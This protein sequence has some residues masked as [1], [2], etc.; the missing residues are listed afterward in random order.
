MPKIERSIEVETKPE[1]VFDMICKVEEFVHL[2]KHIKEIKK[3]GADTF[4]WSVE[5]LGKTFSWEARVIKSERPK[6]FAW[7]SFVGIDNGG[8]YTLTDKGGST[9]ITLEMEY[10]FP[11]LLVEMLTKPVATKL[12]REVGDEVLGNVK[13]ILERAG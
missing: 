2:S 9:L 11:S 4:H 8:S 7:K 10:H 13:K 12:A 1:T 6:H 3:T 5:F